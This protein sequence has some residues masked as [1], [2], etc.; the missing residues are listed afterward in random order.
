MMEVSRDGKHIA[1]AAQKGAKWIIVVDGQEK[2]AHK[3]LLWPWCAW[4]PSLEGNQYIPQTRAAVLQFSPD[5]QSIAY[6]AETED[7]KYAM[8]VNGKPGRAF[9]NIGTRVQFV[10]GQPLYYAFPQDKRIVEVHGER[11]LGPYDTSYNSKVSE[12]GSSE[13]Y[14]SE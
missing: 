1:F 11:V 4:S 13:R 2:Y 14:L 10:A 5:G 9:P 6:P 3:G 8:Y 7:G 12:N